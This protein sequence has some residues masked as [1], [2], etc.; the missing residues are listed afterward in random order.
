VSHLYSAKYMYI[1]IYIY[2]CVCIYMYICIYIIYYICIYMCIY[3]YILNI[4]VLMGLGFELRA[5]R[6]QSRCSTAYATSPVPKNIF[7]NS[8]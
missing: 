8:K 1:Y 4:F 7:K 6:L 2:I 5:S 3:I